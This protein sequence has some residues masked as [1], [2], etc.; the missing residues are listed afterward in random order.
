MSEKLQWIGLHLVPD[1]IDLVVDVVDLGDELLLR[2]VGES[3]C[4][5]APVLEHALG[6]ALLAVDARTVTLDVRELTFLSAGGGGQ[7][8]RAE[9]RL[10]EQSRRLVVRAPTPIVRLVLEVCGLAPAI[11]TSADD[12]WFGPMGRRRGSAVMVGGTPSSGAA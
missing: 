3:D 7:I 1:R 10:R 8:A 5:T 6:A 4:A 11:A 12:L 2:L 9:V